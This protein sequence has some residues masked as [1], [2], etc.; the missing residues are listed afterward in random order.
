MITALH[1][2]VILPDCPGKTQGALQNQSALGMILQ[3]SFPVAPDFVYLIIAD[4]VMLVV[5]QCRNQ[6]EQLTERGLQR[7]LPLQP[8]VPY[9]AAALQI[10]GIFSIPPLQQHL[11]AKSGE[12]LLQGPVR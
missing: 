4:V 1:Q 5:I 6:H 7:L 3:P 8:D 11:I 12:Q 9:R 10:K 2:T